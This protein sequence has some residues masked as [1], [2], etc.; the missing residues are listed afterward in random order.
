[1]VSWARRKGKQKAPAAIL[2]YLLCCSVLLHSF[3][4]LRS[5]TF[6]SATSGDM[7]RSVPVCPVMR[8]VSF[9]RLRF[10]THRPR[11]VEGNKDEE[12]EGDEDEG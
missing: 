4:P 10:F 7:N 2:S 3:H 9:T 5:L 8:Y 12:E 1:M 11:P 6:S